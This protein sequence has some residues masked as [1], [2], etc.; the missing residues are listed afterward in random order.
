MRRLIPVFLSILLAATAWGQEAPTASTTLGALPS[1]A[2]A[3]GTDLSYVEAGGAAYRQTLAARWDYYKTRIDTFAELDALVADKALVNKADGGVLLSTWDF[4]SAVLGAPVKAVGSLPAA[5]SMGAGK[6]PVAV[7]TDGA[8]AVDCTVGGGSHAHLCLDN[9]SAW[10]VVGDGGGG[11]G[12]VTGAT[13]ESGPAQAY[14]QQRNPSIVALP[15]GLLKWL[16]QRKNRIRR[17][18]AA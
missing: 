18:D 13:Q 8:D 4:T 2:T 5:G 9:G 6:H 17:Q 16:R 14:M 1:R 15:I 7:V 12:T 10:V 3:A 11:S